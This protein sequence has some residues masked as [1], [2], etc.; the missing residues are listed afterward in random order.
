M[1][2]PG[3]VLVV[4]AGAAGLSTVEALRRKGFAGRITVLGDEDTAP[5][6]RPPLSKQVL[7]GDWPA[8]RARLRAQEALDALDAGF[9][10]G[11]AAR[12]LDAATRTVRT[13]AG[14]EL[15]A[16]VVVLA[17]GLRPRA[18]PDV[19]GVR[20]LRTLAEATALRGELLGASRV[21]VVGNG[22]LGSEI[23]ATVRG[24]G[25]AVTLVGPQPAPMADQIGSSVARRLAALHQR[26]GVE[27]RDS[28]L[29]DGTVA[30]A[31]SSRGVRLASGEIVGADLV[32]AAVGSRPATD[33][34]SGSGLRIADG[35]V[36]DSRCR[37]AEGVYAVG[38]V[39]RWHHEALG[40]SLR[41]E[42]RTNAGEQALAVAADILGADRPFTPVPYYWSDQYDVKIQVYG[43]PTPDADAEVVEGSLD[44]GRFVVRYTQG[45]VPVGVLGWNMPKQ[46]RPH[47][48][49]LLE[50]YTRA[51]A[52]TAPT[53]S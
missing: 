12:S 47:R 48:Q 8:E 39:A 7:A 5:Y 50:R 9:L 25:P 24:M 3:S 49:T 31:G 28:T 44:E 32:V 45:D 52:P 2:P 21:V 35:V 43:L 13:S 29:V 30:E 4:G 34:L 41:L 18:L 42:N 1:N 20:V 6:D 40:V 33:W 15:A 16:D 37:A 26:H 38:D 19:G 14:R 46:T 17:T 51:S 53:P 23:A 22:V 27:L 10:L 11:E 36:C